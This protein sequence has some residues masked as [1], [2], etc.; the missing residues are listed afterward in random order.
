MIVCHC[1]RIDHRDIENA[2][3]ILSGPDQ[4]DLVTPVA[5]YKSLG[6]APQ[7]GG[8]LAL[9]ANIIHTRT[10]CARVTG[11]ACPFTAD[12]VG[13]E[14]RGGMHVPQPLSAFLIAAE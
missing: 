2:A 14:R 11:N 10:A 8:C 4:L 5:V 12:A 6:K 13:S 9:A 1:N 7:C 3:D